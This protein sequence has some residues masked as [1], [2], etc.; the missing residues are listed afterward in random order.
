MNNSLLVDLLFWVAI[1]TIVTG[2]I[3]Y[4][5]HYLAPNCAEIEI[6]EGD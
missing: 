3:L 2:G 5:Q 1:A 4:V 6:C